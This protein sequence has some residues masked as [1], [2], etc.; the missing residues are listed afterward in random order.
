M[1]HYVDSLKDWQAVA[2]GPVM[3]YAQQLKQ[4]GRDWTHRVE[5]S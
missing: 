2:E 1:I 5:Q 3:R 4:K